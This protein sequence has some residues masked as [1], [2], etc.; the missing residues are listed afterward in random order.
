MV[1]VSD[2]LQQH[3]ENTFHSFHALDI[4][5]SDF[6][7]LLG[8]LPSHQVSEEVERLV[9][10]FAVHQDDSLEEVLLNQALQ[11]DSQLVVID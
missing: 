7:D 1:N 5:E 11:D 6:V 10:N 4:D 2:R 9:A 3:L 8:C